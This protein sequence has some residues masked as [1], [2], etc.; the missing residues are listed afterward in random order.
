MYGYGNCMVTVSV[1]R[2]YLSEYGKNS[3]LQ[4]STFRMKRARRRRD[5]FY[6]RQAQ[7]RLLFAFF[8]SIT[9]LSMHWSGS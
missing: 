7:E 4:S 5:A 6:K 2:E 9:V 3:T 8:M 1:G